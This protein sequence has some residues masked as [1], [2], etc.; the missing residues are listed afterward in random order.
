MSPAA[1]SG[2]SPR[3]WPEGAWLVC[4][5]WDRSSTA[6]PFATRRPRLRR[7]GATASVRLLRRLLS[8]DCAWGREDRDLP[9]RRRLPGLP[10]PPGQHRAQARLAH[11]RV[12]PDDKSLPPRR[13]GDRGAAV[14]RLS[15]TERTLR[16]RLQRAPR[17]LGS[18]LRRAVLERRD[19][20]RGRACRSLPLRDREPRSRR[21][22]PSR[23]GLAVERLALRPPTGPRRRSR[24]RGRAARS[25]RWR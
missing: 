10:R 1:T 13:R 20:R 2:D 16:A 9:G 14:R 24:T 12:L 23:R 22:V 8:R 11:A 25:R 15:A 4:R 18:S 6:A 21:I 5:K 3:T 7:H 17:A 19:R